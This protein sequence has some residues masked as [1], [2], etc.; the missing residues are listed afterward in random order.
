MS[1]KCLIKKGAFTVVP[2]QFIESPSVVC[3][4]RRVNCSLR[5]ER[6]VVCMSLMATN[7]LEMLASLVPEHCKLKLCGHTSV[8]IRL[9][10]AGFLGGFTLIPK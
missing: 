7:A 2:E 5:S 9:R 1:V 8:L 6:P 4:R 10:T 3:F